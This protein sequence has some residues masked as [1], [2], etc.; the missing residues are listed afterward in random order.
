MDA[1]IAAETCEPTV[2]EKEWGERL[3]IPIYAFD[4][5]GEELTRR[6]TCTWEP[7]LLL[8][9]KMLDDHVLYKVSRDVVIHA[10]CDEWATAGV[11]KKDEVLVA[12]GPPT[13]IQDTYY[14]IPLEGGGA[15]ERMHVV[16][17]APRDLQLNPDL[18]VTYTDVGKKRRRVD[19]FKLCCKF[20]CWWAAHFPAGT[21]GGDF[22]D[23]HKSTGG[24]V[25]CVDD[26]SWAQ[27]DMY[28][29]YRQGHYA[30]AQDMLPDIEEMERSCG[31][32]HAALLH[33]LLFLP[34]VPDVQIPGGSFPGV[35]DLRTFNSFVHSPAGDGAIT[36]SHSAFNQ[37]VFAY[38]LGTDVGGI[39]DKVRHRRREM[40]ARAGA[41]ADDI[42][43]DHEDVDGF[44][45][46]VGRSLPRGGFKFIT[47]RCE[48]SDGDA[49]VELRDAAS[50]SPAL[51]A[52]LS[53]GPLPAPTGEYEA[54]QLAL[55]VRVRQGHYCST[56][57]RFARAV[58]RLRREHGE[59]DAQYLREF[60]L[61]RP[62]PAMV[63]QSV[64]P[65]PL[66]GRSPVSRPPS[67]L[68]L[69]DSD[70]RRH[71]RR[72]AA[73][74][75]VNAALGRR[76]MMDAAPLQFAGPP[77][78]DA[79]AT[80]F[81]PC[82]GE[83]L[84]APGI[85][86][87]VRASDVFAERAPTPAGGLAGGLGIDSWESIESHKQMAQTLRQR[88]RVG[89]LLPGGMQPPG[90][91]PARRP[92]PMS[93]FSAELEAQIMGAEVPPT[94]SRLAGARGDQPPPS[95][96]GEGADSLDIEAELSHLMDVDQAPTLC[97][98][99]VERS[100]G[101]PPFQG[102]CAS[103]CLWTAA[104]IPA[105]QHRFHASES[106]AV[107]VASI[108]YEPEA[109]VQQ[110]SWGA[111]GGRDLGAFDF[112]ARSYAVVKCQGERFLRGI[113]THPAK[114]G[115]AGGHAGLA[116]GAPVE[117]AGEIKID[118]D[119]RLLAW[120]LLSETYDIPH[121][122]AEQSG[123]PMDLYWRCYNAGE[124]ASMGSPP[125][126]AR[127]RALRGG[128]YLIR[129][130]ASLGPD[131]GDDETG[132]P[133]KRAKPADPLDRWEAKEYAEFQQIG[134][135]IDVEEEVEKQP[136]AMMDITKAF[137]ERLE[138]EVKGW[139]TQPSQPLY[140][141]LVVVGLHVVMNIQWDPYSDLLVA[142]LAAS[143]LFHK[144]MARPDAVYYYSNGAYSRVQELPPACITSIG[145]TLIRAQCAF[146]TMAAE[147]VAPA[148][149]WESVSLS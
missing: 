32:H 140:D 97:P 126:S 45:P 123:L 108:C 91:G 109:G 3:T 44:E 19:F 95:Q 42:D 67:P 77:P 88:A 76:M 30:H 103:T 82:V 144:I 93:P 21:E 78:D 28:S 36:Q 137:L 1:L 112:A 106:G 124:H 24:Q 89:G 81:E 142:R 27:W 9:R 84:P 31:G 90:A 6:G 18:A 129:H 48:S 101:R 37:R 11:A 46:C 105:A 41:G 70:A 143:I 128:N 135:G 2:L 71:L 86:F 149:T 80:L 102:H 33:A 131:D 110:F 12:C 127:V 132:H 117:F 79:G 145:E 7:M 147:R 56:G 75:M 16:P 121:E 72:R 20:L 35:D 62:Q 104:G 22:S 134:D 60:L 85:S 73:E 5:S 57:D 99:A 25:Q 10:S 40:E 34:E 54:A 107:E 148:R 4:D 58:E 49:S 51:V 136:E 115:E 47:Q 146:Q 138:Q 66:D 68:F 61:M 116:S 92:A 120:N 38:L 113:L 133:R 64:S 139:A 83:R 94:P 59:P 26:Y 53:P 100:F 122:Y 23:W 87:D 118:A 52:S 114:L 29:K 15:V 14:M 96:T 13:L 69:H 17:A 98:T 111:S 39:V 8:K 55:Y 74:G 63:V 141:A 65:R 125:A 130:V 50:P 119:G 43:H